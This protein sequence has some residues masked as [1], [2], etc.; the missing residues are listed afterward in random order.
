MAFLRRFCEICLKLGHPVFTV[1]DFATIIFTEPGRQS[2][3]QIPT[4]RLRS[5]YLY[6]PVTGWPRFIS[7][8]GFNFLRLL[9]PGGLQWRYCN[10]PPHGEHTH[11]HTYIYIY[12]K[13][14]LFL[15]LP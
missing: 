1:L 9:R 12:I 14:L 2:S 6:L 7:G 5:V 15:R 4:S 8:P 3:V 11:T 13:I 10:P